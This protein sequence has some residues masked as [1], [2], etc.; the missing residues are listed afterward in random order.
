MPFK[1]ERKSIPDVVVVEKRSF[2]D[3]RGFF[4]ETYKES[5]FKESGINEVFRQDNHSFSKKGVVRGLHFQR[6]PHAQG[7][8]VSVVSGE[9]FDVVVDI[10]PESEYFG[11]WVFEYLSGDNHKMLWIP[12]G[13]LHG[14]LAMEDS[15]VIY[16][17]TDEFYP[18]LDDGIIWNDTDLKIEWPLGKCIVSEKDMSL[19]TFKD[20][21]KRGVFK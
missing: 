17:A 19:G 15:H 6:S 12:E 18:D 20:A 1:F 3:E 9:I 21:M 8:L 14:F 2:E 4:E 7:K 5:P 13:F 10:R 16:K 11:K